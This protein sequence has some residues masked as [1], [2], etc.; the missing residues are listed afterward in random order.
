MVG[1]AGRRFPTSG[2]T[3]NIFDG[4]G[5]PDL[6]RCMSRVGSW[7]VEVHRWRAF[8]ASRRQQL[9]NLQI[10]ALAIDPDDPDTAW[11]AASHSATA[12]GGVYEPGGIY[13][14]SNG[15]Q[16]WTAVDNGLTGKRFQ[17]GELCRRRSRSCARETAPFTPPIRA[18]RT[19][20]AMS[21][22]T[23]ARTGRAPADPLEVL[24]RRSDP[25]RVGVSA[26]A[27]WWSAAPTR[28]SPAPITAVL[29]GHG[30]TQTPTGGWQGNGFWGCGHPR[31]P[32]TRP[33]H[34]LLLTAF[35]PATCCVPPVA[36]GRDRWPLGGSDGGYDG[37]VG[38]PGGQIVYAVLGQAGMFNGIAVSQNTG[39]TWTTQAGGSLPGRYA[40]SN[41][42]G[43]ISIAST[44]PRPPTPCR[45]TTASTRPPTPATPGPRSRSTPRPTRSR[46]PQLRYHLRRHRPGSTRSPTDPPPNPK[47]S[48]TA[49]SAHAG[50]SS[51][52][53]NRLRRRTP[54]QP[55]LSGLWTNRTGIWTRLTTNEWVSDITIDP[56]D[57]N[58]IAYVTDD[59]PTTP[60]AQPPA[61][62]SLRQR[63]DLHPRQHRPDH[64][65][66]L[67]R[68]RP[69]A[70]RPPHHRHQR[71]RLLANPN[72]TCR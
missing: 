2:P 52:R 13:E 55:H 17:L 15:G 65:P 9:W 39:Q 3:V 34:V 70:P 49:R 27:T 72:P 53:R 10:S 32:L 36:P 20:D 67:Q 25:L 28:S 61:P 26:T 4:V 48:Q 51:P 62:G 58:H 23:A 59:N 68:L 12:T 41:G 46:P 8:L 30:T 63:P 16:S 38:G 69:P 14:T 56:S 64:D 7:G 37:P 11:A 50:S 57:R 24:S 43:S 40:T 60:P 19:K 6:S 42:Q 44:T 18:I 1:R 66:H 45:P 29:A 54:G 47:S 5:L 31:R 22:P 35:H 33:T 21:P 71:P